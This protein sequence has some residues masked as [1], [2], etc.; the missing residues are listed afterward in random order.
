MKPD[1][2]EGS[3]ILRP[4]V[5]EIK[6]TSSAEATAALVMEVKLRKVDA[7]PFEGHSS[8]CEYIELQTHHIIIITKYFSLM[9]GMKHPDK[10]SPL[11]SVCWCYL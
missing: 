2:P 3:I 8:E 11:V 6:K 5:S 10:S 4:S 1:V 9:T 7:Q